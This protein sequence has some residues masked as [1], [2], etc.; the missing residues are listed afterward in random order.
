[1]T[2]TCYLTLGE[3]RPCRLLQGPSRFPPFAEEEWIHVRQDDRMNTFFKLSD[4]L[5]GPGGYREPPL[6]L[7]PEVIS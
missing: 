7:E 6:W 2:A 5:V 1:M 4:L 3:E